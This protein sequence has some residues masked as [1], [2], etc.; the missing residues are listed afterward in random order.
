MIPVT[1]SVGVATFAPEQPYE[2]AKAFFKAADAAL[3]VA[4][5]NGR[6]RVEIA[7]LAAQAA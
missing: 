7:A 2:N 4:K 5:A 3:Y 1:T 6:N